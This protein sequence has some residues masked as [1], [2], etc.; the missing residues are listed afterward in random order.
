[1]GK[2]L[3]VD[4]H[5]IR[6][7]S[8]GGELFTT[9]RGRFARI[10]VELNLSKTLVPK[11]KIRNIIYI[12]GYEGLTMICFKC[13]RYRHHSDRCNNMNIPIPMTN[14]NE[15]GSNNHVKSPVVDCNNLEGLHKEEDATFGSWMLVKRSAGNRNVRKPSRGEHG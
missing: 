7:N 5:T 15:V 3:K 11:L 2:T 10:S 8:H 13:G 12:I 1:M 14:Q 4:I 6:D 9:E